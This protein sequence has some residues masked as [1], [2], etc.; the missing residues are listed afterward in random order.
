MEVVNFRVGERIV[1]FN[2][3]NI[4][5]TEKF[6]D[7]QTSMPS[8]DA[9]FLGIKDFMGEPIPIYDL[10]LAMNK[11]STK[12][13]N[14]SLIE[15]F[16]QKER[17]HT[18]WL[19]SLEESV[20]NNTPF[21]KTTEASQS[22][23]SKWYEG[24]ETKNEDLLDVLKKIEEPNKKLYSVAH[25]VLSLGAEGK[26]E[27]A[28]KLI[29]QT[30]ASTLA[31]LKRLYQAAREQVDVAYKPVTVFTTTD[32]QKPCLGFVVDKVEDS[33]HVTE[34]QVRQLSSLDM[35]VGQIDHRVKE[36]ITS[37]ITTGEKNSL[38][39]KPEAFL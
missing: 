8:E 12:Q 14:L 29:D 21:T 16:H 22:S 38:L 28:A 19:D 5:L 1:A 11:E 37:L 26:T 24:F 33:L 3:L 13:Y 9:S 35:H 31:I 2:I 39:L 25:Q 27:E 10:G 15:L 34:D 17:E 30:K 23:F 18:E 7:A 4:L 6:D 20:Q 36:M 32:G